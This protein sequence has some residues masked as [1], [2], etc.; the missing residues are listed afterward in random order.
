MDRISFER[1]DQIMKTANAMGSKQS[2]TTESFE[3]IIENYKINSI[4]KATEYISQFYATT[5]SF[6]SPQLQIETFFEVLQSLTETFKNHQ[7]NPQNKHVKNELIQKMRVITKLCKVNKFY[8]ED[9]LKRLKEYAETF[10]F[11]LDEFLVYKIVDEMENHDDFPRKVDEL[12]G[13]SKD[14]LITQAN[15]FGKLIDLGAPSEIVNCKFSLDEDEKLEQFSKELSKL[16]SFDKNVKTF[17]EY[18]NELNQNNIELL[19]MEKGLI[20]EQIEKP[21]KSKFI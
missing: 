7:K 15:P 17:L 11:H 6:C 9:S 1:I 18:V 14:H 19:H 4:K 12:E 8:F 21:Q 16:K 3:K 2:N 5:Q 20:I 13:Y 10:D